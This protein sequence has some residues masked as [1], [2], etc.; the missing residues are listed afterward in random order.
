M[1]LSPYRLYTAK[2]RTASLGVRDFV[3]GGRFRVLARISHRISAQTRKRL[4]TGLLKRG[5]AGDVEAAAALVRLFL[6]RPRR[7]RRGADTAQGDRL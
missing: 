4:L 3:S 7:L 2:A 1:I 6:D 5:D